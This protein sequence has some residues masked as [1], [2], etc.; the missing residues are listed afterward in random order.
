MPF[1]CLLALVNVA[2]CYWAMFKY[3]RYF[4]RRHL[5]VVEDED[6]VEIVLRL[7]ETQPRSNSKDGS[8]DHGGSARRMT[9]TA[10]PVTRGSVRTPDL[11][12]T[13]DLD[14]DR[15]VIAQIPMSNA[16]QRTS[17]AISNV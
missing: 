12:V 6:A 1:K 2:S 11:V 10:I 17:M 16:R 3:A 14:E 13:S 5:K 4:A 9:V 15:D 8:V 7:E